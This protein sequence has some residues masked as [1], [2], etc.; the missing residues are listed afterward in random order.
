V[1]T[2]ATG[3]SAPTRLI[4]ADDHAIVREGLV[5]LLEGEADITVVGQAGTGK[6]ALS[7]AREHHPDLALLDVTMP[8]MNGLDATRHIKEEL[9]DVEVLILTMHSEDAFFFE[10]LRAGAAGYVLK[11]AH[12]EE[13][14][15]AIRVIRQGGVHLSPSLAGEL[16]RD[17]LIRHPEPSLD[18]LL[19]SRE[20]QVLTLIAKGFSN[21]EIAEKLTL[22][23]NTIKTHRS[24]IYD[25]LDLHDRASLV[26]YALRRG[27]LHS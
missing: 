24:R 11:G 2:S 12:S 1:T 5:S 20:Q 19:T 17:Y 7:L 6:V 27:L 23:I 26:G 22:S 15:H 9:P 10:A 3:S 18:D 25:K 16:V 13:L 21:S 8:D 14:L 4:I